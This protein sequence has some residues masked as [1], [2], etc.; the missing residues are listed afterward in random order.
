[1]AAVLWSSLSSTKC[2]SIRSKRKITDNSSACSASRAQL[3][4]TKSFTNVIRCGVSVQQDASGHDSKAA[5][6][7]RSTLGRLLALPAAF[8][9]ATQTRPAWSAD[10]P[11]GYRRFQGKGGLTLIHPA[12]WLPAFVSSGST[13]CLQSLEIVLAK[14]AYIL[15]ISVS[16]AVS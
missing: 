10:V 9:A 11:Q 6:T 4:S 1:M 12:S 14:A 13:A 15:S 16:R 3:C 2:C 8:T 7:R 5:T